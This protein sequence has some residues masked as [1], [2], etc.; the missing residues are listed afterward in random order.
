M[1]LTLAVLAAAVA[2]LTS[3]E[4][5]GKDDQFTPWIAWAVVCVAMIAGL[6]VFAVVVA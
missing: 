1:L 2:W 3:P 6:V 4:S 5:F